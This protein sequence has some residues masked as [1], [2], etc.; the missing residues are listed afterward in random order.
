VSRRCCTRAEQPASC[1]AA[2]L[3]ARATPINERGSPR[4][5]RAVA[6]ERQVEQ[7]CTEIDREGTPDATRP[8]LERVSDHLDRIVAVLRA[9]EPTAPTP[10]LA[11]ERV[12]GRR[13]A[14]EFVRRR[15]AELRRDPRFSA[16]EHD[17][18]VSAARDPIGA[19]WSPERTA[20]RERERTACTEEM[21]AANTRLGEIASLLRS[22]PGGRQARVAD[23]V[24][25]GEERL[26]ALRREH[27]RLALLESILARAER[28][29]RE[30]HQPPV[31]QR[32]SDYLERVTRGRWRRIDFEEG[33][34][35]GLFVSGGGCDEPVRVAPP[36][37]RGTLDQI[38]LCLRL[39]LLDHLDEGR[40]RLPLLLDDALLRMDG[41]RRPE[42][43]ELLAGISRGRQVLLLTCQEWIAAEAEQ[44]LKLHRI[45]LSD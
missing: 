1:A 10:Q 37:S 9:A 24:R 15:E 4:A 40:E 28:R 26:A 20:A 36:L 33:A 16:F 18:R 5:R 38:F 3:A 21:A 11:F 19:E 7:D 30:V 13:E 34:G 6:R 35:G 29:F 8:R 14:A 43:Y 32:A 22:D 42:V 31:L 45:T 39:G 2:R 25:E 27:D 12:Q 17:A 23:L 44:A 41:E